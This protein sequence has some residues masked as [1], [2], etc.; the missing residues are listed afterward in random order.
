MANTWQGEY[1][2]EVR[3]EEIPARMLEPATR[4]LATRI[5]EE[6]MQRSLAPREIE[7]AYTPRRL[8]LVCKGLPE[9]EP[10]TEERVMGPPV[11]AAFK[12]DGS[13]TGA[14]E[15]FAKRCGVEPSALE[16]IATEKG[17]YLAATK[18]R[19]GEPV[20]EVL[21][22]IVPKVLAGLYW[23]KT[24]VWGD[25]HGPW[26]RPVHGI[27]SLLDGEVVPFE[28]F[29]IA[30]GSESHGHPVL[31][32]ELFAVTGAADHAAKLAARGVLVRPQERRDRLE[33][34][35]AAA[36]ARLGGEATDDAPLLDKLAAICEIPG[37]ME[38]SFDA[39]FLAL[40]REVLATS[41]R[42]HQS[43]FAVERDG[44]LLPYFLTVMDRPDD[45]IGRVRAGNEWVVAARLAD[46][47]F[48]YEEDRKHTLDQ[49][50]PDLERLTFQAKLG[51]YAAKA[52]R[53]A[54]LSRWLCAAL[55]VADLAT[56]CER[57][58]R[59][60]KVDLSTEMV[61]EFTTLQGVMGGIYAREEGASEEVWQ[62]IYDQYLPASA[63]DA[64]PR[65]AV[66]RI[67]SIADR[68]DTLAGIFGLGM[69]PSGS[70]DPFGLRRAAQGVVRICLEAGLPLDL[71]AAVLE[72]ARLYGA[73]VPK[74]AEEIR[75]LLRPFFDDRV[76]HA[77]GQ[78]GLAYDEIEAALAAG[79][80]N[81]PELAAR[82]EALHRVRDEKDFLSLTL[83]AKRIANILKDA[84]EAA[85]DAALLGEP[86]ERDLHAA[87]ER[88]LGRL[89]A[90]AAAGK[91]EEA[92]RGAAELAAP[93]DRFF[94]EVMVMAED[95]RVRANRLALLQ[96]IGRG[97]GRTARLTEV[98]VDRAEHRARHGEG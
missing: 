12:P 37:V 24:M 66:G 95:P 48:F 31:S 28:L 94:T 84:P 25:G 76:R 20:R 26:V 43:A 4:E 30:A 22:Q 90:A 39:A 89:E 70:R 7:T 88:V 19:Q 42:D 17:E 34:G 60:L 86:A 87:A 59:L 18:R 53:L 72:A 81:L 36:A 78:R 40:P 98:V 32:P 97:L 1:L 71:D 93:L 75:A 52:E 27:V 91:H 56:A 21:A 77:L 10:D 57:A 15:G 96:R 3:A 45:P 62:A 29:G 23:A 35:M 51:S 80:S 92:L 2:L 63:D 69:I 13:A 14:L 55:G 47:R 54:G 11:S 41:L 79:G 83:S 9:R 64:I 38:G 16:R 73:V 5:F 68:L 82:A 46:A 50:A 8:V 65:G 33:A 49:R 61:K 44:K 67:V 74:G 6:L 58:A 85:F